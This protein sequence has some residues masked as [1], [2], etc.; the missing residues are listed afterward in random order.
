M[1]TIAL[2]VIGVIALFVKQNKLMREV[3]CWMAVG[4]EHSMLFSQQKNPK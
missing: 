4:R 3:F 1:A 2:I